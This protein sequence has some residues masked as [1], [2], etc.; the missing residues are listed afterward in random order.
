MGV[1]DLSDQYLSKFDDEKQL[2]KK[3][4]CMVGIWKDEVIETITEEMQE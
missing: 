4:T 1:E 2:D 3:E